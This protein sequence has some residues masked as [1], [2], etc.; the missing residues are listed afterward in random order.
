M[1]DP[2]PRRRLRT[3]EELLMSQREAVPTR[4]PHCRRDSIDPARQRVEAELR[5]RIRML[6]QTIIDLQAMIAGHN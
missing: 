3:I 2:Q 5:D 6:E 1:A 4:C